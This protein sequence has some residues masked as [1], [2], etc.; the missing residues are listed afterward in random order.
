MCEVR[1]V[2]NQGILIIP[3]ANH[4]ERIDGAIPNRPSRSD[5]KYDFALPSR[6]LREQFAFKWIKKTR[7]SASD[8]ENLFAQSRDEAIVGDIAE[9][10]VGWSFAFL[11]DP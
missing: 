2:Q 10:L 4:L 1:L 11:K 6:P 7:E 5:V 9:R 8:V 3:T